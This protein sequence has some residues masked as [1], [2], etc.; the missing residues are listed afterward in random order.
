M[1]Y[2]RDDPHKYADPT[3]TTVGVPLYSSTELCS[4]AAHI[5]PL[6]RPPAEPPAC[7]VATLSS[8][9]SVS[10]PV[11][12]VSLLGRQDPFPHIHVCCDLSQ[13]H[14]SWMQVRPPRRGEP[15]LHRT[16]VDE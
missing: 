3:T 12:L 9:K 5:L 7:S 14:S 16:F 1:L 6:D 13:L 8:P 10:P 15:P 11:A 4:A 2:E